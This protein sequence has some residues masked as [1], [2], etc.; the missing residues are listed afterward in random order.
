VTV[1]SVSVSAGFSVTHDCVS[2]AAG[3]SCSAQVSFTPAAQGALNGSLSVAS[4]AG[5]TT[6]ALAGTGERS[7]VT[8]YYR[9]ILRRA[10]DAPGKGFWEAEAARLASLG[11][12]VNETWYAM[13]VFFFN[14]PEYLGLARDDSGFVADLFNTFFNRPPDPSGLA[15]WTGQLAAGMP[16]EVVLVSF[17]LSPEFTSFTEGIFGNTAARAE[18]DTV[19][20]FYRGLLWRLP[21]SGGFNHWMG[22][23]RTAQCQGA[24]AVYAQAES[25]S[26]AFLNG[27]E[28]AVRNRTHSQFVGDVYN[29]FLRRGGDL[30][31]VQYWIDQLAT[32]DMA[33]EE[34]RQQFIASPEFQARVNAIVAQGCMPP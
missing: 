29:A 26:S 27:A 20:D 16:R 3:A 11:A 12:N 9:S 22:Q 7:L 33:R 17:M 6:V 14:S 21:D 28:Y 4:S 19:M 2:L 32:F 10:P 15:F 1:T 8:H 23:F 24:S 13:A 18:V 30:T 25:I 34:V 31:G 5:S